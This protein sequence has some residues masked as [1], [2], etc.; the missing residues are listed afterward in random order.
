MIAI[1]VLSLSS[2]TAAALSYKKKRLEPVATVSNVSNSLN[3]YTMFSWNQGPLIQTSNA[4]DCSKMCQD[5][6]MC[7]MWVQ[8]DQCSIYQ[9]GT[10]IGST[11]YQKDT[12][13]TFGP[14]YNF[15]GDLIA[16]TTEC[17]SN[18]GNCMGF[19]YSTDPYPGCLIYSRGAPSSVTAGRGKVIRDSVV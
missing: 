15:D 12:G 6:P 1:A 14:G 11:V 5:D 3:G 10:P 7:G 9:K 4:A 16:C 18:S 17:N 19:Q 8:D 13:Y 2:S